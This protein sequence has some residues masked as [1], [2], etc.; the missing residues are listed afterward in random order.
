MQA[1]PEV[2]KI[3]RPSSDRRSGHRW[4]ALDRTD[5]LWMTARNGACVMCVE[6]AGAR[7]GAVTVPAGPC[8][9]QTVWRREV[10]L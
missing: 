10:R 2:P 6:Q 1:R 7:A 8:R 3:A 5:W 4:L 9:C